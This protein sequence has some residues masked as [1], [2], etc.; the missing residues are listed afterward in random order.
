[1]ATRIV[2]FVLEDSDENNILNDLLS[3]YDSSLLLVQIFSTRKCHRS[4]IK[5]TK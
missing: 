5:V 1:M 4:R 3:V 2:L